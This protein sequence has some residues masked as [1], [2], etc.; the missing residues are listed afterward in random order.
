MCLL[1]SGTVLG[2]S[3]R[4]KRFYHGVNLPTVRPLI[5]AHRGASGILPEHTRKICFCFHLIRIGT[6]NSFLI[7]VIQSVH[8]S[9]L[10]QYCIFSRIHD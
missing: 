2:G 3:D 1:L 10:S 6:E 9:S 7:H 5:I 8:S 4:A